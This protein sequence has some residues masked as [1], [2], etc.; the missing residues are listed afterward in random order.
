MKDTC[1]TRE[2]L[3]NQFSD[4]KNPHLESKNI[5]IRQYMPELWWF[6]NLKNILKIFDFADWSG[7]LQ[8]LSYEAQVDFLTTLSTQ[9]VCYDL[10]VD[11]SNG[12]CD[13]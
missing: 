1:Q 4:L 2:T 5:K 6:E 13:C 9:N 3:T 7:K 11:V 8:K 10:C 12:V